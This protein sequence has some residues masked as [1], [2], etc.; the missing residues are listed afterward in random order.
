M[1]GAIRKIFHFFPV[2]VT[3][4]VYLPDTN[5]TLTQYVN[6]MLGGEAINIVKSRMI[7]TMR[8]VAQLEVDN[9]SIYVRGAM[10]VEHDDITSAWIREQEEAAGVSS[11]KV[12]AAV[13]LWLARKD[14]YPNLKAFNCSGYVCYILS[15]V[16]LAHEHYTNVRLFE[17]VAPLGYPVDG[18]IMF[19]LSESGVP[20]HCG[21]YFGGYQYHSKNETAGVVA[22]PFDPTYWDSYGWFMPIEGGN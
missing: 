6:D 7:A 14:N 11:D 13:N 21:I 20:G 22:E 3:D 1:I 16:G 8:D 5:I 18:A 2:T 12:E 10:A 17:R 19:V 9:K 4:A 15:Q